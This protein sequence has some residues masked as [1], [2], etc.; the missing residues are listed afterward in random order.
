MNILYQDILDAELSCCD[1]IVFD[2]RLCLSSCVFVFE[3]PQMSCHLCIPQLRVQQFQAKNL[4]PQTVHF[5][6]GR[7]KCFPRRVLCQIVLQDLL[8]QCDGHEHVRPNSAY[9][10]LCENPQLPDGMDYIIDHVYC[11]RIHDFS[12]SL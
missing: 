12:C 9:Q 7:T 10:T 5:R 8:F 4:I 2:N 3:F 6:N 1:V 11:T